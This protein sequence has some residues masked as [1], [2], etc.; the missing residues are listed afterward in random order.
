MREKEML[1]QA[2]AEI[3]REYDA[4]VARRNFQM[5]R[6]RAIREADALL[7]QMEELIEAGRRQVPP[8]LLD[9][10]LRFVRPLSR[11][12]FRHLVQQRPDP[13]RI[14]DIIFDAQQ[15]LLARPGG[16]VLALDVV[17]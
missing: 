7:L 17:H 5:H 11:K 1:S 16:S 4:S 8:P 2:I 12:L 10:V 13:V 14:L 6:R 9:E 15:L 3:N